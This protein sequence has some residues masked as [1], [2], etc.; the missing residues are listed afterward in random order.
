MGFCQS[1][2]CIVAPSRSGEIPPADESSYSSSSETIPRCRLMSRHRCAL[3]T[4][5]IYYVKR[6]VMYR[7]K[8]VEPRR[9]VLR[10]DARLHN[11]APKLE[12][13]NEMAISTPIGLTRTDTIAARALH[14]DVVHA[15]RS[16]HD[17]VV[18]S[19]SHE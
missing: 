11:L 4:R 16:K 15:I 10:R 19:R 12:R 17:S 9:L 2:Q 5:D 18:P 3:T 8:V 14:I 7:L 1:N 13:S 6:R